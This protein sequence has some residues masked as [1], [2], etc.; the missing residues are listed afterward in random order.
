MTVIPAMKKKTFY[1]K[2]YET[3]LK[4]KITKS[5]KVQEV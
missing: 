1:Y 3:N 5:L 4:S 2:G